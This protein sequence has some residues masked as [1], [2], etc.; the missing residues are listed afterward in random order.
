MS[1]PSRTDTGRPSDAP[2]DAERAARIE[3]LLLS[4]LDEYF[5][6]HYE[7]AI[8]IWTRVV[9]LER[10]NS[11]ARAYI[12]RARTML[13]ERQRESEELMHRGVAAYQAGD[14]E[15]AR[16]CLTQAIERGGA[17]DDALVFLQ[18]LNRVSAAVADAPVMPV[19]TDV[20]APMRQPRTVARTGTGVLVGVALVSALALGAAP[21]A[22]WVVEMPGRGAVESIPPAAPEALPV[23]RGAET[24]LARARSLYAGGHLRDALKA[25]ERIDAGDALRPDADR[26]RGEIQRDL[27]ASVRSG[28]AAEVGR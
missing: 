13:A 9:F 14:V 7:R 4:G 15:T 5:A 3:Q 17:V 2:G 19:H 24:A 26:L 22:S 25:V 27:L 28:S 6:S 16:A 11:R 18:R 12:D 23:V 1:E 21:L 10:G 8:N 20:S